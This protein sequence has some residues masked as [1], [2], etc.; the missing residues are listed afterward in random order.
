MSLVFGVCSWMLEA[1]E[2]S[3]IIVGLTKHPA[4]LSLR[5]SSC[6]AT[7]GVAAAGAG[8]SDQTF[9]DFL[10]EITS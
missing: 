3:D 1:D 9:K 5:P 4:E 8:D 10:I 6:L 7:L 2:P